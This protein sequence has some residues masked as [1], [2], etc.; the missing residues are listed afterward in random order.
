MAAR[1]R[2][3]PA[4]N[5]SDV[6]SDE[7]LLDAVL[8]AFGDTGFEGTSVREVARGLNVSHNL[9]PQ[10]FGSKTRLWYAAVDYGFGALDRALVRE[11]Q[12]LGEDQLVIL[13]GLLVRVLELNALNPA[14][15]QIINQEASRP[16]PRLDYLFT[17]FIKPANDFTERWLTQLA[18][19]GRI[20]KP[21]P[22]LL[23]FLINHGAG[24]LIAFPDLATR[25]GQKPAKKGPA[26]IRKQAEA[27]VDLLF[28]GM[29]P[30]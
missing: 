18:A 19:D 13:R 1:T 21:A 14:L 6:V 5:D 11:G 9:I 24:S 23:Y 30:R 3:R 2:G 4:H 28:A 16:G 10:R 20:T 8:R 17:R 15:L 25:L 12:A 26:S 27:V 29:L 7:A 22:G